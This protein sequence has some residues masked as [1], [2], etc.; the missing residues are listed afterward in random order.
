METIF[1][2]GSR[3]ISRLNDKIRNRIHNIMDNGFSII[4]GDANGADKALQEFLA[5]C[6]YKD[7]IIFCAGNTCRNNLGNWNTYKV[8]VDSK[9]KGRAF[10]TQKDKEMAKKADY[11]LV[12]WDGK[13]AGSINNIFELLKK[14]KCSVVY[15]SPNKEFYNIKQ[16]EDA[17]S[18]LKKCDEKSISTIK[19]KIGL[20]SLVK[21]LENSYQETLSF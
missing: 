21:N 4:I 16:L 12:L 8:S 11:G 7:V 1:L 13:S 9:L 5:E 2:S 15:F 17:Q 10:Y 18:L 19:K 20:N 3:A 6:N 14:D